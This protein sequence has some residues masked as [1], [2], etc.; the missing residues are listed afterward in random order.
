MYLAIAIHIA[1]IINFIHFNCSNMHDAP[2]QSVAAASIKG[3]V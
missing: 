3:R 2:F 1:C